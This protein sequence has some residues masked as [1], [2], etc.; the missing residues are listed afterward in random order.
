MNSRLLAASCMSGAWLALAGCALQA[1]TDRDARYSVASCHSYAF[2][3]QRPGAAPPSAAF[4]NPVNAQ[5]LREAIAGSLAARNLTPAAEGTSADCLVSYALGSRLAADNFGSTYEWGYAVPP[6]GYARYYGYYGGAGWGS[7]Y[8]YREGRVT[9]DLYDARSHQALW[10]AYVDTDVTE[11]KGAEADQRIKAAVA[12][13]F[14]KF[15]I[16]NGADISKS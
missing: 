16:A 4:D 7:P 10:H 5:R 11:L 9:V 6:P 3:D 2:S 14:D 15:P 1:Q 13:I 8:T 12:A